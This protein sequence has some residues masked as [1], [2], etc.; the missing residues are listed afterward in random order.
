MKTF[1][2]EER[3]DAWAALRAY[4]REEREEPFLVNHRLG[5]CLCE[6]ISLRERLRLMHRYLV[7]GAASWV[8][9]SGLKVLLLRTTGM[10]IGRNV[11]ISPGVVIDPIFPE[12]IRIDDE[13]VLGMGCRVLT[14]EYTSTHFRVARVR[15]GEGAVVGGFS[16]V[17]GGV[18]V[19]KRATVGLHSLVTRDVADDDTVVG[20]PAR[21]LPKGEG[22]EA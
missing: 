13:A 11:F 22:E 9:L 2:A 18:R 16:T 17:R 1:D 5:V 7:V 21:P 8:P 15:I 14:H 6:R 4:C 12:L 19:G 3:A 10:R 20:V